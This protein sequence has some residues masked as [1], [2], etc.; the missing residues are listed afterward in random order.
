VVAC[1][2]NPA[3]VRLFAIN[4]LLDLRKKQPVGMTGCF[5]ICIFV[6]LRLRNITTGNQDAAVQAT[7]CGN[8]INS[9]PGNE[10]PVAVARLVSVAL[11][12]KRL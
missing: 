5:F 2:I 6:Y 8:Q 11:S 4:N 10:Y 3:G 1:G 7:L 12:V 9:K